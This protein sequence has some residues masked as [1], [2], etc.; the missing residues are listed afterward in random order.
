[1]KFLMTHL[2]WSRRNLEPRLPNSLFL[3]NLFRSIFN[4]TQH[5]KFLGALTSAFIG[6]CHSLYT[7]AAD[8]LY[9]S[10]GRL[11]PRAATSN[12]ELAGVLSIP[13]F[14]K[15]YFLLFYYTFL[16]IFATDY[17]G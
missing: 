2:T 4:I 3:M 16:A 1:M 5:K 6:A 10:A 13:V 11:S 12:D 8:V 14:V 17:H 15:K 9:V 7:Y